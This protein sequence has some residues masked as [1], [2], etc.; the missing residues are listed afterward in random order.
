MTSLP[1]AARLPSHGWLPTLEFLA[2]AIPGAVLAD[3]TAAGDAFRPRETAVAGVLS[4]IAL[5][6]I[7][8]RPRLGRGSPAS[9]SEVQDTIV[10]LLR[11]APLAGGGGAYFGARVAGAP[12]GTA[13]LVGALSYGAFLLWLT[14]EARRDNAFLNNPLLKRLWGREDLAHGSAWVEITKSTGI[15]P[16]QVL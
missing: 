1:T 5:P 6:V 11:T 13:L 14:P 2:G 9:Q 8:E 16:G 3:Y 15:G 4:A 7:K 10:M 12:R